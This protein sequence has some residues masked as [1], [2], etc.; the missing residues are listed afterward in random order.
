MF[1]KLLFLF[2][3]AVAFINQVEASSRARVCVRYEQHIFQGEGFPPIKRMSQPYNVIGI[4]TDGHELNSATNTHDYSTTDTY[5]V[6]FWD[7]D[8]VSI[9]KSKFGPDI[10]PDSN[11]VSGIWKEGIDQRGVKWEF[12]ANELN[13]PCN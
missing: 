3:M 6:I 8:Q 11:L 2:F 9:I 7:N 12:K 13:F 5:L 10:M 4:L 1:K